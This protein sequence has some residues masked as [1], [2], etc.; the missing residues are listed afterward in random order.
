MNKKVKK[1]ILDRALV[2][3][4]NT[5]YKVFAFANLVGESICKMQTSR[6]VKHCEALNETK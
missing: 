6:T 1:N 3:K 4:T 2:L 5:F